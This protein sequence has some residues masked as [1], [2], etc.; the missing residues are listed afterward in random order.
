MAHL[1]ARKARSLSIL[2]TALTRF[3]ARI[4][5]LVRAEVVGALIAELERH[6]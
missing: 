3:S 4:A 5:P 6:F 1:V 2:D